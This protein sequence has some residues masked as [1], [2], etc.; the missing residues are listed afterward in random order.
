MIQKVLGK[1]NPEMCGAYI[2]QPHPLEVR[3]RELLS[4]ASDSESGMK[5]G[6]KSHLGTWVTACARYKEKVYFFPERTLNAYFYWWQSPWP[7]LEIPEIPFPLHS[8][9]QLIWNSWVTLTFFLWGVWYIWWGSSWQ[10]SPGSPLGVHIPS[11]LWWTAMQKL[12]SRMQRGGPVLWRT[13]EGSEL[14]SLEKRMLRE[15]LNVVSMSC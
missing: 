15:I 2:W 7:C 14:L 3:S 4:W 13:A 6:I 8:K 12:T 5:R 1:W 10:L 11:Q 9:T